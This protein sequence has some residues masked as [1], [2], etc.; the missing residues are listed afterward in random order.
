M[1]VE[2][3]VFARDRFTW[4]AY[5]MLAYFA[6]LQASL[7]P[8]MPFLRDELRLSYTVGGLHFSALALGMVM[9]GLSADRAVHRWGRR[10]VFWAG[11]GGMAL[12]ALAIAL[13]PHPALTVGGSW[14]M[15]Y[16]GTFVLAIVQSSLADR[17]GP[18]RTVA[19]T[20]ANVG[21]SL[22]VA[23]CPLLVGGFQ[24][25]GIGWQA[26]LILAAG[27]WAASL[28][29]FRGEPFPEQAGRAAVS[30]G[31]APALPLTFWVYWIVLVLC[32]AAEWSIVSW[33]ADFLV[34]PGRLSKSDASIVM[35][36]FFGAMVLG[37]A[38]GSRMSRRMDSAR[39]LLAA[40]GVALA[41]FVMFWLASPAG[42]TVAGLFVA[43][44]GV[45]NLFPFLMA[46]AVGVGAAQTDAASA[47]VTLGA[48]L[49]ILIAPQTLGGV[50]D[51]VDLKSAF[52]I[53]FGLLIVAAAVAVFANRLEARHNRIPSASET[54]R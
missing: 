52:S 24:R 40:I 16:L 39:L 20:E 33:G 10:T 17:H 28:L 19:L 50:A 31:R 37:R 14:I 32:V 36:F 38:V 45:S 25:A 44:L 5:I 26:A 47:R 23:L 21:A 12:G 22:I 13:G 18:R 30:G 4:L 49:A 29:V 9:A 53:V 15:G 6:Y 34:N 35:T 1:T 43:G 8:L 3:S 7:G 51:Q 48:G 41:G 54:G 11:G 46:I 42:L 27:V 2:A